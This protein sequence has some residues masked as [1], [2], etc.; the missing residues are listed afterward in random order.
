VSPALIGKTVY[1]Q[2]HAVT[3]ADTAFAGWR[4]GKPFYGNVAVDPPGGGT[5]LPVGT[6]GGLGFAALAGVALAA[7][8]G[9]R[10][11]ARLMDAA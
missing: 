9:R 7:V 11:P 4:G 5:P 1:F 2:V 6:L 3:G 8:I 10:R